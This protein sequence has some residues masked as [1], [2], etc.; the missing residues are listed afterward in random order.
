MA[1]FE[2]DEKQQLFIGIAVGLGVAGLLKS[3]GPVFSEV[4]RPFAKATIKSGILALEKGRERVAHLREDYEDLLAE[5]RS[6]MQEEHLRGTSG[7]AGI[8]GAVPEEPKGEQ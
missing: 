7:A 3:L 1:L 5:V 6:E 8:A 4:G 2:F